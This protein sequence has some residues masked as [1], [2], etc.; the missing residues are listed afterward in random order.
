MVTQ[1][2]VTS[3]LEQRQVRIFWNFIMDAMDDLYAVLGLDRK[4]E[5]SQEA[6]RKAYRVKVLAC[7]PDKRRGDTQSAA[8]EFLRVKRGIWRP[9][10]GGISNQVWHSAWNSCE[11]SGTFNFL[12]M[13]HASE[14][15]HPKRGLERKLNNYLRRE[16]HVWLPEFEQQLLLKS[17]RPFKS[18]VEAGHTK[19]MSRIHFVN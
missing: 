18:T 11:E 19:N 7:H 10:S 17:R 4:L 2:C 14:L 8:A 16:M 5:I 3:F 12:P 9:R 15:F 1:C 13:Q 6:I